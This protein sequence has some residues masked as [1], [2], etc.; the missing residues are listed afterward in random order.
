MATVRFGECHVNMRS[1]TFPHA[2]YRRERMSFGD[3]IVP[4]LG[5]RYERTLDSAVASNR[6]SRRSRIGYDACA[7]PGNEG[8]RSTRCSDSDVA[9]AMGTRA[10]VSL[11]EEAWAALF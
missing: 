2:I 6:L 9:Q 10:R 4:A 5:Y 7:L 1:G 11:V 8:P 3:R